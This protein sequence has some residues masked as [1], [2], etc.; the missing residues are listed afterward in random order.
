[1]N[2]RVAGSSIFSVRLLSGQDLPGIG[3][4]RA[5]NDV[6]NVLG[7]ETGEICFVPSKGHILA[8]NGEWPISPQS[9]VPCH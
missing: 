5:T 3:L 9:Y 4:S 1:M 2:A 6:N 8:N 7:S